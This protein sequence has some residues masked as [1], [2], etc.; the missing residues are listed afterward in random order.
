MMN[1]TRDRFTWTDDQVEWLDA[2]ALGWD[3]TL[4]PRADDGKFSPGGGSSS[5]SGKSSA[6]IAEVPFKPPP[7]PTGRSGGRAGGFTATGITNTQMGDA[8]E[9]SLR[10]LGFEDIDPSRR[11]GPF[12]VRLK[13]TNRV[14]E[15]K[16]C[17]RA[18]AEYKIKMKGNELRSKQSFAKENGLRPGMIIAVVDG[19]DAH[20]YWRDGVGNYRLGSEPGNWRY[21]GKVRVKV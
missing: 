6:R 5:G 12:D 7:T 13:G 9:S 16:A 3:E 14:F 20:V 19:S 4:H 17:T 18:A 11:Q 8:V 1:A 21:A 10:K 2:A 15:V